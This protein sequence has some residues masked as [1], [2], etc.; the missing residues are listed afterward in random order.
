M[1]NGVTKN[2]IHG[3]AQTY[4]NS[5]IYFTCDTDTIQYQMN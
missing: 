2:P 3:I 4:N 1:V 5:N